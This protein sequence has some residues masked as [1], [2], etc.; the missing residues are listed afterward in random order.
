[1]YNEIDNN[2]KYMLGLQIYCVTDKKLDILENTPIN[3]CSVNNKILNT[4]YLN[5]NCKDNI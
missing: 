4:Q 1:M 2:K 3:L 5:C